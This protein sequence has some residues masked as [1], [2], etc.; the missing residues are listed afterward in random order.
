[1]FDIRWILSPGE[2]LWQ[3]GRPEVIRVLLA[4][5]ADVDARNQGRV[6]ALH[7]ASLMRL[8]NIIP[9]ARPRRRKR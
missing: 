5:I 4:A 8:L 2:R 3:S 6:T 1:V 9:S 7:L